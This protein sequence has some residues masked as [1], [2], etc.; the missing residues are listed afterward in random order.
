MLELFVLASG[1]K[2]NASVVRDA[3]SGRAMLIDC[4]IS[5]RDFLGRCEELQLDPAHIEAVLVTHAHSDHVK[6]LGVV[7]RGLDKLGCTPTIFSHA[8]TF[9]EC[10]ALHDLQDTH[11]SIAI[12]YNSPFLAAGMHVLP[13]ATSHDTTASLGFR[14]SSADDALG[15]ITDTGYVTERAFAALQGVR[16]LAIESNHD[17]GMLR[18][19]PY[20][21]YLQQRI[22]SNDG[23]LSNNQC[24]EAVEALVHPGLEQVV[25]MHISEH[26]NTFGIPVRELQEVLARKESAAVVQAGLPR[27][28][29]RVR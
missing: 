8:S 22:L 10:N 23:H 1:S 3:A 29:V 24:C 18:E 20:P 25:A 9:E 19:G 7:M 2:G 26:N 6:G 16:I 14:I 13:F 5:K 17:V 27:T 21:Y 12:A 15:F 11:D 4:G 28:P